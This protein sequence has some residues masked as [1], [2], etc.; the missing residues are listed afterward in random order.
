MEDLPL[1]EVIKFA[2]NCKSDDQLL[3]VPSWANSESYDIE[4]KEDDA[5]AQNSNSSRPTS[6]GIRSA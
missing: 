5:T 1:L 2:Y 3:G 6:S 4:A